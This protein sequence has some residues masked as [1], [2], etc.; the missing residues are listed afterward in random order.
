MVYLGAFAP[1][2][3]RIT[4]FTAIVPLANQVGCHALLPVSQITFLKQRNSTNKIFPV[5]SWPRIIRFHASFDMIAGLMSIRFTSSSHP[6]CKLNF[7]L[8]SRPSTYSKRHWYNDINISIYTYTSWNRHPTPR[9]SHTI[10]SFSST[11]QAL[12]HEL[13]NL[14]HTR[15]TREYSHRFQSE[16]K[17]KNRTQRCFHELQTRKLHHMSLLHLALAAIIFGFSIHG[18]SRNI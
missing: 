6:A 4:D 17:P 8:K 16:V 1:F 2:G 15:T 12:D 14:Y 5:C 7:E 18:W 11:A 3:Y 10:Y 13:Q 9:F